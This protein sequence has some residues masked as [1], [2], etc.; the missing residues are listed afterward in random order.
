MINLPP[1]YFAKNFYYD[2]SDKEVKDFYSDLSEKSVLKNQNTIFHKKIMWDIF[3]YS[4]AIG[5]KEKQHLDFKRSNGNL[6]TEFMNDETIVAIFAAMFSL[7]K[8][9]LSILRDA[10]KIQTTCENY[11]NYGVRKLIK[12]INEFEDPQEPMKPYVEKFK[13]ILSNNE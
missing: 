11:A 5:I 9:D 12:L 2:T 1:K 8:V 3:R 13:E 4:L 6:P 10:K 7:D